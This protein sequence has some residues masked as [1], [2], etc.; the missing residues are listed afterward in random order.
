MGPEVHRGRD[1][2]RL[3]AAKDFNQAR[4]G[5]EKRRQHHAGRAAVNRHH[6]GDERDHRRDRL[7]RREADE[8][9]GEEVH[10]LGFLEQ[11]DEHGDAGHHQDHAP[12]HPANRFLLLS[13]RREQEHGC[14]RER[15]HAHVELEADHEDQKRRDQREREPVARLERLPRGFNCL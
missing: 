6:A 13:G 4:D 8:Q 1:G 2:D 10:A 5:R 12:G 3:E 9:G 11:R 7:R 15:R 14:R